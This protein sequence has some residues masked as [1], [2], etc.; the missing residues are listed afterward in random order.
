MRGPGQ[1]GSPTAPE[2]RW[3]GQDGHDLVSQSPTLAAN[4]VQDIHIVLAGL[5]PR[6]KIVFA[7]VK[8]LGG[9]E[10][11]YNGPPQSWLAAIV[12]EPGSSTA[13]LF[14]DPCRNET[15]RGFHVDLRFDDDQTAEFW[16]Q[17]GKADPNLRMRSAALKVRWLG[18]DSNDLTGP[19]PPVG[20]DGV[21][22]VHLALE[23]VSV[24][25]EARSVTIEAAN[26]LGWQFGL[27][28]SGLGNAELVRN[29]K[30]PSHADLFMNPTR[31]LKGKTLKVSIGYADGKSDA[32]TVV[33]GHCEP[34]LRMPQDVLPKVTWLKTNAHWESR[35]GPSRP[36]VH[37]S[38]DGLPAGKPIVAAALSNQA[39]SSWVFRSR[40]GIPFEADPY[41]F[42]LTLKQAQT[43]K[44]LDVFF[45]PV[46][47][48]ADGL[49]SL[50]LLFEDGQTAITEFRGGQCDA[51]VARP[52]LGS[53]QEAH[54]GDDLQTIVNRGGR[55]VLAPGTY[56]LKRPLVLDVP[57]TL[58]GR[59][60]TTL[61]F[62]QVPGD[63]PWTTAIK[64]HNGGTA[65]QNL[66]IRFAGPI[67]WAQ[68]VSYGPAVIGTTDNHDQGHHDPKAGIFI[69][70]LDIV[71]P[72]A[73]HPGTWEE[74]PRLMRL[75]TGQCGTIAN[76]TLR[77]GTI[78]FMHGP[79]SIEKNR[80]QG[81]PEWT[82][83]PTVFAGHHTHDLSLKDNRARPAGPSGKTWR[84]LVLTQSG[85]GDVVQDN[86]IEGIG[87]RDDDTIP[88]MNMP[89]IILTEAYRL[90][91]EG[92]LA[93]L[94]ANGRIVQVPRLQGDRPQTGDVVAILS[95]PEAGQWRSITQVL[96]PT[97]YLLDRALTPG[98]HAISIAT[99]F[100]SETFR[101][102]TIDARG[103]TV[104]ADL[105]L[106]GNH[107][108]TR[109]VGN[110]FLGG[111]GFRITA[112]PTEQPVMWGW[113]HAP[114]LG[115]VIEG[116]AIEDC[117]GGGMLCVEHGP[118]IK[119]N[120]GRV[121]MSVIFKNNTATWSEAFLAARSQKQ[122]SSKLRAWTIGDP[123]SIDP[124]EL[125]VTDEGNRIRGSLPKPL[126]AT[127][128]IE[129]AM[130]NGQA[131]R[132]REAP[133]PYESRPAFSG[134]ESEAA[135]SR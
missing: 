67:R 7:V 50:R 122:T 56:A 16:V 92:H 53:E 101:G 59:T 43:S 12:R 130:I 80:Y 74:A 52:G 36:Q 62:S 27:N 75:V 24:Q 22:D 46:R 39:R 13:D 68:D 129:A 14:I 97:T 33:A 61:V 6:K 9:D 120:R 111:G 133:L 71:G 119:S 89:E 126:T 113:S 28:A 94:A 115:G 123:E 73:A 100:V 57:I 34:K 134:R 44:T 64:I 69:E 26:E 2:G 98:D 85:V 79:W 5:P 124:A 18:Q 20:P 45:V 48:E 15:G 91:F 66:A 65:L 102:N 32:A 99:G 47:D 29:A 103:G 93:A 19:G 112:A 83:T 104:A 82:Y 86:T 132:G 21:Q 108:G 35:P 116:N 110:H 70:G 41:A 58:R 4:G 127:V 106:A 114:F 8:G 31:E 63:A 1:A 117:P 55:V 37:V 10:W 51:V 30:D 105:V 125:F 128:R 81:T 49:F 23:Q 3:R 42:P 78:E 118:A 76:N 25:A 17:G 54:P 87:P 84:F 121:Y 90:H 38:L 40:E 96:N 11:H 131:V 72:P 95:G 135:P 107:F 77:G 88:Q 109:V 60:G